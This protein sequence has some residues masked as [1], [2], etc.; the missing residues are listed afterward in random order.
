MN[1]AQRRYEKMARRSTFKWFQHVAAEQG[2]FGTELYHAAK[3][4]D[5]DRLEAAFKELPA[6]EGLRFLESLK[7]RSKSE[8]LR[9]FAWAQLKSGA[10]DDIG[11]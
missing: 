2:Y 6:S 4:Q 8:N 10:L 11:D 5:W 3:A 7:K 1:R 9:D